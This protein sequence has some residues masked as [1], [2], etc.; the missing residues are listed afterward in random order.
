MS[1]LF[2]QNGRHP[3][4]RRLCL[5]YSPFLAISDYSVC[6][7]PRKNL[8]GGVAARVTGRQSFPP[9]RH[10]AFLVHR[11]H[12]GLCDRL[13]TRL[14][15]FWSG[16]A[17]K[18]FCNIPSKRA[19]WMGHSGS[20]GHNTIILKDELAPVLPSSSLLSFVAPHPRF[21][22]LSNLFCR[23]RPIQIF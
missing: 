21:V 17:G 19:V 22:S 6:S 11:R 1:Q 9:L 18:L 4:Q 5:L 13:C 3:L 8:F 14:K 2:S 15:R 10:Q 12:S 23:D 7:P 20:P 16:G